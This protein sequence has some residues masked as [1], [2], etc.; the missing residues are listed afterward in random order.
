M[1]HPFELHPFD[2][3]FYPSP[4]LQQ[5]GLHGPARGHKGQRQS[6]P[7]AQIHIRARPHRGG[8]DHGRLGHPIHLLTQPGL[9]RVEKRV[10]KP[11]RGRA[12]GPRGTRVRFP[13]RVR[14]VF[15]GAVKLDRRARIAAREFSVQGRPDHYIGRPIALPG[16]GGGAGERCRA[17]LHLRELR[18]I[19]DRGLH[20]RASSSAKCVDGVRSREI[21]DRSGSSAVRFGRTEIQ[22]SSL[23]RF[24]HVRCTC[25]YLSDCSDR[26]QLEMCKPICREVTTRIS[27]HLVW[28]VRLAVH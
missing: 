23:I 4:L 5:S 10:H 8:S 13:R 20:Y 7:I 27:T 22:G 24:Y 17:L 9:Q 6:A 16:P 2:P 26:T 12:A 11:N 3:D 14:F 25:N 1:A 15:S 21:E 19:G 28:S 18:A